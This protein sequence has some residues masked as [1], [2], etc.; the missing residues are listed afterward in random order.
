MGYETGN[1][2]R[3][4]PAWL[5]CG[6]LL[7]ALLLAAEVGYRFA[8]RR[9]GDSARAEDT[10]GLGIILGALLGLLSLLLGFTYSYVIIR[11][12]ARK[13]AIISEANAIGTAY[14]RALLLPAPVGPE[15]QSVLREYLDTRILTDEVGQ[16]PERLRQATRYSEEVQ[17]RIWPLVQRALAGRTPNPVDALLVQS[18]NEV[19]DLHT[20]RL[21]AG[22]DHVPAVVMW[23]LS[24][25]SVVAMFLCGFVSG[26]GGPRH[27]G[28]DSVIAVM[29]VAVT[30]I[31]LDLDRPRSGFIRVSQQSLEDLRQSLKPPSGSSTTVPAAGNPGSRETESR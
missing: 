16:D 4:A 7:A 14:L 31:I 21:A 8:R 18:L 12:E 5:I 17:G 9:R 26:A 3:W 24:F 29:I 20:V 22:R 2:F 6:L 27:F 25:C 23:M 1:I 10:G 19:I 15:L 11:A 13:S 30:F 28:R